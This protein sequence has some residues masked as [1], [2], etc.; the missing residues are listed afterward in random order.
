MKGGKG[1]LSKEQI[2][3][4]RRL[5]NCQ[6][7][8]QLRVAGFDYREIGS[9][10]NI[11]H[12]EAHRRVREALDMSSAQLDSDATQLRAI[13]QQ[14]IETLWRALWPKA[15]EG[16]LDAID[17]VMRLHSLRTRLL[18]LDINQVQLQ[19]DGEA[20]AVLAEIISRHVRDPRQIAL[21]RADFA[22]FI[23]TQKQTQGR[24]PALPPGNVIE[25]EFED[26]P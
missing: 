4:A 16:D 15:S 6:R 20:V 3:Q 26:A 1:R 18:G 22:A 9:M 11:T 10:E 13:E 17:R 12:T 25:G 8:M 21:I 24:L 19:V 2:R 7:A 23:Q 5:N 14:R